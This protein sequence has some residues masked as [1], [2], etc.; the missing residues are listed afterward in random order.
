MGTLSGEAPLSK[1][2]GLPSENCPQFSPLRSIFTF[3]CRPIYR[4]GLVCR[5]VN[6]KLQ[7]L[8]PLYKIVE[9]QPSITSP[10]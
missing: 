2:I 1:L 6:R 8:S 9:N 3:E 10:I 4:R 5:N 7:K